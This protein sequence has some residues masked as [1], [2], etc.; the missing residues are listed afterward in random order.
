M[1][2][3]GKEKGILCRD[4]VALVQGFLAPGLLQ[5]VY[6]TAVYNWNVRWCTLAPK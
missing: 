2:E 4:V 6:M 3:E 1:G 5:N